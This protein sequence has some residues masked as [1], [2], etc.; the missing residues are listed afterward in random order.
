MSRRSFRLPVLPP[1]RSSLAA[2]ASSIDPP[3]PSVAAVSR[4]RFEAVLQTTGRTATYVEIPFDV[5]EAFGRARPPVRGSVNGFPF[6]STLAPYGQ[7]WYL[8]VNRGVREGA[9]VAAGETVVVEL[10]RDDEP[11]IVEPPDDLQA[12]LARDE[13]ARTFFERLSYTHR[14]EYVDWILDA[15][16]DETR[17]RRVDKAVEMLRESRKA[18]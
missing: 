7:A 14:K 3:G 12:A 16:R 9:G 10:E 13:A 18:R 2:G 1:W 15:K 8:V 4:Q 5:R 6:R 17:R 11:R